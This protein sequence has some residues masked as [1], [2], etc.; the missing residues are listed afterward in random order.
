MHVCCAA[1][2]VAGV[3]YEHPMVFNCQ[4]GAGRTTTGTVIG[5]LLA[6]Y[7]STIQLN[8]AAA[9]AED[10]SAGGASAAAAGS[11]LT[12]VR[13]LLASVPSSNSMDELS[14]D[15][16]REELA[17]DSPRHSGADCCCCCATY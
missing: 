12:P 2:Q 4:M 10:G 5:G 17:G 11:A 6:M 14:K 7:G 15:I 9:A 13:V 16:I 8:G 1:P 3:G